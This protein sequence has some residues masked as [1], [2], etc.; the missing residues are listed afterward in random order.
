MNIGVFIQIPSAAVIAVELL[1]QE[2]NN[3][4]AVISDPS[5]LLPR[6]QTI[7]VLSVFV[8]HLGAY[9]IF[10]PFFPVYIHLS[11]LYRDITS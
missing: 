7:Q 4:G 9:S 5:S 6:S 1:H 11:T 2:Q 3:S 8:A 10:L